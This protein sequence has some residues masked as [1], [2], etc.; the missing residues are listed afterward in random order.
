[1]SYISFKTD[2][3]FSSKP[4]G[5]PKTFPGA[6]AG[7]F[8]HMKIT[9]RYLHLILSSLGVAMVLS[10][11]ALR[12]HAQEPAFLNKF[13]SLTTARTRRCRL[14]LWLIFGIIRATPP[15]SRFRRSDEGQA[16]AAKTDDPLAL[17]CTTL[18]LL[19]SD[20]DVKFW[21]SNCRRRAFTPQLAMPC[22]RWA[23]PWRP[24]LCR[25]SRLE[26]PADQ[27]APVLLCPGRMKAGAAV[28]FLAKSG[29][30]D[31]LCELAPL[32]PWRTSPRRRRW[33]PSTSLNWKA[34]DGSVVSMIALSGNAGGQ[35]RQDPGR[36]IDRQ[37][38]PARCPRIAIRN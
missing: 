8:S 32:R 36:S 20:E 5:M 17:A 19:G 6:R 3:S 7:V 18:A 22:S 30:K 38:Q 21:P 35:R 33:W 25:I 10:A 13:R 26:L 1:M 15:S 4:R 16:S 14:R 24:R 9:P 2:G 11:A 27:A 23:V 31:K 37:D 34:D 12:L 29:D 28:P